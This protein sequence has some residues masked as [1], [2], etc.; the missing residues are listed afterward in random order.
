MKRRGLFLMLFLFVSLL[1]ARAQ[2]MRVEEFVQVRRPIWKILDPPEDKDFA[3]LDLTT[4]EK[5]FTFLA[6][7]KPVDAEEGDGMITVKV[8]HRTAYLTIK[9]PDY[10]Q[11][12]W[13]VPGGKMMKK[14]RHYEALLIAFDPTKDYKAPRQWVVFHLDP[15]DVLVQVDS[16]K[17]RVRNETVEYL[18]PVGEHSYRVES[19]FHDTVEG[20]FTLADSVRTDIRVELQPFWSF[21]TVKTPWPDGEVFVDGTQLSGEQATSFRLHEGPHRVTVYLSG[22]CFYDSLLVMGRAEKKVL[23]LAAE[24]LHPRN[25]LKTDPLNVTPPAVRPDGTEETGAVSGTTVTLRAPDEETEIWLDRERVGYGVWEGWLEPGFHLASTRRN[26][27]ESPSTRLWI[28]SD[29]PQEIALG[30]PGTG[31]GLLNIHSNVEGARILIDGQDYGLTPQIIRLDATKSYEL[32]LLKSGYRNVKKQVRPR[33][34]HQVEVYVK[35]K[36]K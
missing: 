22:L 31:F 28:D 33:G 17:G 25:R 20:T 11:V 10:G 8:P 26:G 9:H 30:A 29:F 12:I 24:D 27:L 34:N 6:G 7:G 3:L 32:R 16:V 18:L 19:P 14:R 15:P 1:P 35:L 36:K 2:Q 21:L 4:E 13:R 23:E 5:G